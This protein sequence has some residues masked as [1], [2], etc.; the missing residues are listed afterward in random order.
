[1]KV[2]AKNGYTLLESSIFLLHSKLGPTPIEKNYSRWSFSPFC[3]DRTLKALRGAEDWSGTHKS[4][5]L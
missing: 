2:K 3:K 5:S 1:M 4:V